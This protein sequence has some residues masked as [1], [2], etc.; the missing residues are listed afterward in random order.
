ML[1]VENISL[2]RRLA[3]AHKDYAARLEL[4]QADGKRQAS[5]IKDLKSQVGYTD[6]FLINDVL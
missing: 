1:L 6:T 2:W 3:N 4:M 5:L